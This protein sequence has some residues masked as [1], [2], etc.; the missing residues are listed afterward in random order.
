MA[1]QVTLEIPDSLAEDAAEF[2]VLNSQV[3]ID[4]LQAEVDRR[5]NEMVNEEIHQ[6]RAEKRASR[7]ND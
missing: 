6:Y 2:G 5:I 3:I 1:T 7:E 4:L